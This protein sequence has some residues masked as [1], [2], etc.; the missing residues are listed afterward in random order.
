[1]DKRLEPD[2]L[3]ERVRILFG[4]EP[5]HEADTPRQGSPYAPADDVET[6]EVPVPRAATETEDLADAWLSTPNPMFGGCCPQEF[7]DGDQE[8]RA[9]L[10]SV[11][12][13]FEDGAFS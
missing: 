1:M 2:R 9:F 7:L 4:V 13:S 3:Y 6:F 8:P 12:S 11:L 10:E 5:A